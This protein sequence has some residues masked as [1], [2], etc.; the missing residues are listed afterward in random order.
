MTNL[1]PQSGT[2]KPA[3]KER[4][5][6]QVSG[7]SVMTRTYNGLR[8]LILTYEIKPN[9]KINELELAK[10]FGVSRTPVREALSR[11]VVEQLLRFEPSAGFY[12]PKISAHEITNLYEFRVFLETE[13]VRLAVQRA[14]DEEIH[15]LMAFWDEFS[16]KKN[17]T[18]EELIQGDESFHERLVGLGQNPEF[19]DALRNLNARIHF[20]RWASLNGPEHEDSYRKHRELLEV[21]QTRN[22]K[23]AIKVL[24]SIIVKRQEELLDILK[25]GAAILY[26]SHD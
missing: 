3:R 18:K 6:P 19:V 17:S 23:E 12:R 11:L 22:E 15:D 25:E 13:G 24:R 20:I 9:E 26:I 7:G 10:K 8:R 5:K 1:D 4:S 2:V 21:L 14:K 16:A